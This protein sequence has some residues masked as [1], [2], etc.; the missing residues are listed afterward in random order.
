M[1]TLTGFLAQVKACNPNLKD[2]TINLLKRGF[3]A[4]L[5][6]GRIDEL[7]KRID[8]VKEVERL[9]SEI[10]IEA[11][12]GLYELIDYQDHNWPFN[13]KAVQDRAKKQ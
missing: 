1:R 6:Q 4:G 13:L 10:H 7:T 9:L 3:Q 2:A 8:K 11:Q 5:I 12:R